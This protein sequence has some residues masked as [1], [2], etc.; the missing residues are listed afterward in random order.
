LDIQPDRQKVL[1]LLQQLPDHDHTPKLNILHAHLLRDSNMKLQAIQV[2]RR[3][4]ETSPTVRWEL[5]TYLK[6]VRSEFSFADA[7]I[8]ANLEVLQAQDDQ[9]AI[10]ELATCF[11]TGTGVPKDL[12][13][14]REL[15]RRLPGFTDDEDEASGSMLGILSAGIAIA[16]FGIG[17]GLSFARG[18][19]N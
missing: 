3:A 19:R 6:Q 16:L 14:A 2:L 5:V 7:E 9:Q 15:R 4:A 11:E 1:S 13:Q 10:A 8:V 17:L 18:K 12:K